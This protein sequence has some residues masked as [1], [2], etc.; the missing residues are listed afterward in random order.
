MASTTGRW[1]EASIRRERGAGFVLVSVLWILVIMT[2]AA[3][4]FSLWVERTRELAE[5][6]HVEVEARYRGASAIAQ[7]TYTYM[8]GQ[9]GVEGVSWPSGQSSTSS[10]GSSVSFS[11]LDDFL[12]GAIPT[13]QQTTA[14]GVLSLDGRVLD[15]GGGMRMMVRDRAGLVGLSFLNSPRVFD[16]LADEVAGVDAAQLQSALIDYQDKDDYRM[17]NGVER[18]QY[19][20]AGMAPPFNGYLRNPLQLRSVWGW[21][22]ALQ[23][24]SDAWLLQTFK[25]EGGGGINANTASAS[26]LTLTAPKGVSIEPILEQR[27][28]EP[29]KSIFRLRDMGLGQGEEIPFTIIPASGFRLWWWHD[30]DPI[31]QVYDVQFRTLSPGKLA[32]Y[33]NWTIRVALPNELAK[34]TATKVDHPFFR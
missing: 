16:I 4:A 24:Y 20:L 31:A 18:G 8:V 32:R 11:S 5:Q 21:R 33:I 6:K 9:Q 1:R 29:Y 25:V 30:G 10:G 17:R 14:A 26:A 12:S 28:L 3:G 27:R 22:E 23:N 2:M 7:V 19:R 34:A 15:V 13:V